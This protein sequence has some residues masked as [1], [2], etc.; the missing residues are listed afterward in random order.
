MGG[1][2]R[3]TGAGAGEVPGVKFAPPQERPPFPDVVGGEEIGALKG[4]VVIVVVGTPDIDKR[5]L[6][7]GAGVEGARGAAGAGVGDK[8]GFGTFKD[9]PERITS[10]FT[11]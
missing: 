3:V 7:S 2:V 10:G 9:A 8:E 4:V 1:S 6:V 5:L 11:T